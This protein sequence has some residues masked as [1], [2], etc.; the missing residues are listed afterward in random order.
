M[1]K[2]IIGIDPGTNG[3]IAIITDGELTHVI[4]MPDTPLDIYEALHS[5]AD[6]AICYLEK[7]GGM[8]GQGGMAMFNFGKNFGWLEMALLAAG[9]STITV[10]PQ[11]WQRH[12]QLGKSSDKT[13][14]EWKNILKAKAQ[15]LFPKT[16]VTLAIADAIL[17]SYYGAVQERLIC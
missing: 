1:A 11:K 5:H 2:H 13:K 15:S 12:Y 14:T 16:K 4:K 8:P 10:T 17:I 9:I 6:D 7:V 3:G